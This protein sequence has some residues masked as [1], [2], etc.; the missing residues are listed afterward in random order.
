MA[1]SPP[2]N[3]GISNPGRPVGTS[4]ITGVSVSQRTP[5]T[6][7]AMRAARVGGRT[8]LRRRGHRT[9]T[10]RVTMAMMKELALKSWRASGMT[11]MALLGPPVR[12]S[13]PRNGRT[14]SSMMMMPMPDMNPE[15]T[16]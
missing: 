6:V 13:A 15:M 7:P 12:V 2:S 11:R 14:W 3:R 1:S 5:M 9:P 16:E 4:P 8:L 10:A